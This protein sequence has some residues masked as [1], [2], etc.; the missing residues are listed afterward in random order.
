MHVDNDT[1]HK[2]TVAGYILHHYCTLLIF[3]LGLLPISL[4]DQFNLRQVVRKKAIKQPAIIIITSY[5]LLIV[6]QPLLTYCE[7][8]CVYLMTNTLVNTSADG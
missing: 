6:L 4:Q 8:L 5:L 1:R 7:H 2:K 3:Y